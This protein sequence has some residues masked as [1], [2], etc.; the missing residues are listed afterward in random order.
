MNSHPP[1]SRKIKHR[2]FWEMIACY[3]FSM[4]GFFGM[5]A[6][7]GFCMR[8][9]IGWMVAMVWI[10]AWICQIFMAVGWI[11]NLLLPKGFIQTSLFLWVI[12]FFIVP[13]KPYIVFLAPNKEWGEFFISSTVFALLFFAP[14]VGLAI[15][16]FAFHLQS[17][18]Q[19]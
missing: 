8:T 16:L 4:F 12:S 10:L 9:G 6:F 2:R 1:V 3:L 18:K 19:P 7:I 11:E 13:C 17:Y 15:K 5:A 14:C